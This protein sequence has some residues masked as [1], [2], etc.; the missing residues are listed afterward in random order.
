MLS[1]AGS[2]FPG[3][4]SSGCFEGK[5]PQVWVLKPGPSAGTQGGSF[6]APSG[7]SSSEPDR[8]LER[9]RRPVRVGFAVV[10][11]ARSGCPDFAVC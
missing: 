9:R 3:S 8:D 10:Y 5:S 6:S 7:L 11:F 2:G 1:V 4:G